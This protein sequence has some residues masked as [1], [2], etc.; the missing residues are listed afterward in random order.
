MGSTNHGLDLKSRK[1]LKRAH[2]KNTASARNVAWFDNILQTKYFCWH[3][4]ILIPYLTAITL[5]L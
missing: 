2:A 1:T 5:K 3:G 4:K